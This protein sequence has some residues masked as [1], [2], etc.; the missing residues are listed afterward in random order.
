[1]SEPTVLAIDTA[2]EFCSVALLAGA[3]TIEIDERVGQSHSERVLPMVEAVLAEAGIG[4]ANVDA[5][6]FGAGPGAF[7]GL[8]I[9]CSVAQGLGYGIDRPLVPVGNLDALAWLAFQQVAHAR[10]VGVAIDAR[11]GQAYWA[12]YEGD[13]LSQRAL[14]PAALVAAAGLDGVLRD[15]GVEAVAGNALEA[16]AEQMRLDSG[17]RRLGGLRVTAAAIAA[18]GRSAFG[19]GACVPAAQA[20][21]LYVRERVARTIEERGRGAAQAVT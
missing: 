3:R 15:L 4:L 8:R 10:R 7:T 19:L 1:M 17:V 9:A 16:F 6:A 14:A 5:I 20:A 18:C 21:P 12:A 2:T 13:A 11:M